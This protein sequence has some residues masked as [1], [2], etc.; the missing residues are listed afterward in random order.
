MSNAVVVTELVW[1]KGSEVFARCSE[2][3]LH[4]CP[5][6]EDELAAAVLASRARA[7]IVG[8]VAY[9]GPLYEALA[10][11]AAGQPA[12]IARFGVGHDGI[13]KRQAAARNIVVTNTPGV[14]ETSV[15]EHTMLLIGT[16]ARHLVTAATNMKAGRFEAP[17]G[18]ELAGRTLGIVGFGA[19]GSRV[20]QIAH[21]GFGMKVLAADVLTE[22]ELE[23]RHGARLEEIR[24]RFGLA[25]YTQ[26]VDAVFREADVVSI[27]VPATD[28]TRGLVDARRLG[29][30]KPGALLVN[31]A[32]GAVL[33]EV[34]LYEAL[35]SK[36]LAGAALDVFQRE[37]YEPLDPAKDLRTL[38]NVLLTPH[39]G[40]NTRESN[41][42][43]AE[44]ALANVAAFFAGQFD[45][46]TR[47][48]G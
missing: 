6:R 24:Q 19:I 40:S 29:L 47:V 22:R 14:L 25:R 45:R 3:S 33:D 43:M 28:A 35:A 48:D 42:R 41:R 11:A 4:V 17:T 37:P 44:A 26:D 38:D 32:R 20:A 15:A 18:V 16:L 1:A 23:Q 12:I 27:H 8:A 31:T 13:D 36:Q 7:A 10:E 5:E 34:A 2:L 9:T 46:L 39:I 21:F 30:M